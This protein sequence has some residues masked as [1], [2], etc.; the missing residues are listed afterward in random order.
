MHRN[1][2]FR[3]PEAPEPPFDPIMSDEKLWAR[4]AAQEAAG[5]TLLAIPHNSKAFKGRMFEPVDNSGAPLTA[6][7]VRRRADFE[8]LIEMTLIK[9]DSKVV[10][11]L[12]P[13]DEFAEFGNAQGMQ[14][15]SGRGSRKED[16]V[17]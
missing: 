6:E 10:A 8:P 13:A 12:R 16:P 3:D 11:S 7:H 1:I 2:I 17:R 4:M 14:Q 5:S 15:F 9:S